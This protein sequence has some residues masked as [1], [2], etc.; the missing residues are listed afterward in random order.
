MAV[1]H[2]ARQL[3]YEAERRVRD[4]QVVPV[5]TLV[6]TLEVVVEN[7]VV[8]AQGDEEVNREMEVGGMAIVKTALEKSDLVES[9]VV[10][11]EN[12]KGNEE[13]D[14][15]VVEETALEKL[16]LVARLNGELNVQK[17]QSETA[18]EDEEMQK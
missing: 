17:E 11:R 7:Q 8:V 15:M 6:T 18:V 2:Y 1:V 5:S 14:G 12:G 10:A 4:H 16:N 13:E 3:L 9:N